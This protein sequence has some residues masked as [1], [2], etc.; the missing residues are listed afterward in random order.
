MY[1]VLLFLNWCYKKGLHS[2]KNDNMNENKY[3]LTPP[4]PKKKS[5]NKIQ[6]IK[7]EKIPTNPKTKKPR[8]K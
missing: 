7:K 1:L 5:H 4:P 3:T 2:Q 8:I 6:T